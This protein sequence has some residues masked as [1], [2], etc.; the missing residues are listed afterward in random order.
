MAD[1]EY[2][3][4]EQQA[5]P[6]QWGIQDME[7]SEREEA[8]IDEDYI[9]RVVLK[10]YDDVELP[11]EDGV[12]QYFDRYLDKPDLGFWK[13]LQA[14]YGDITLRRVFVT[15]T[16]EELLR[17]MGRKDRT[18]PPPHNLLTYFE[19]QA[20]DVDPLALAEAL[21][22]WETKVQT[23]YVAGRPGPPPTNGLA[24]GDPSQGYLEPATDGG[25]DA[26]FAWT[27][28][29]G[30]GQQMQFVDL[31]QGW[32]LNHEDLPLPNIPKIS[33]LNKGQFRHGTA[34]LGVVVAVENTIGVTGIAHD[35]GAR[36]ISEWLTKYDYKP[37][38]AVA[39]AVARL[40]PGDVLLLETQREPPLGGGGWRLPIEVD[41]AV[42]AAIWHG[43]GMDGEGNDVVIIE[44]AG[45]GGYKNKSLDEYE[46]GDGHHVLNRASP[47][48][49]DSGAIV[50][51]AARSAPPHLRVG[52]SNYGSR[53]DCYAWGENI[54]T[55]WT[56]A[57]GTQSQYTSSFGKTSG[58]SAIIAGA[59]LIVQSAARKKHHRPYRPLQLREILSDPDNGTKSEDPDLNRKVMPDLRKILGNLPVPV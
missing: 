18:D 3:K 49:L 15:L 52:S 26:R 7:M 33:G 12:E 54:G 30:A 58:A 32:M 24:A 10:F 41:P 57:S 42:Y 29:G 51:A 38:N 17:L 20:R 14:D 16:E 11:Y 5:E 53:V 55:L 40:R 28:P 6:A 48:F 19:I 50:V 43:T 44:P 23:A 35:A 13:G 34:A 25:I 22:A 56:N 39:T 9:P 37:D 1:Q 45:N 59:A 27:Q 36:V 31:E 8:G 2:P 47:D 21:R 46:N 4:P